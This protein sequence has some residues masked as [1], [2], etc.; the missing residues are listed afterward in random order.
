MKKVN[1][2]LQ[3]L[4]ALRAQRLA[5]P[6][7]LADGV[8][9]GGKAMKKT[10]KDS[11]PRVS[12]R[13]ISNDFWEVRFRDLDR[14]FKVRARAASVVLPVSDGSATG[15][16]MLTIESPPGRPRRRRYFS[17]RENIEI[18]RSEFRK[19]WER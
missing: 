19:R 5:L 12:T 4:R 14:V 16:E 13:W 18:S 15:F 1:E 2:A 11:R 10:A 9:A 6:E 17:S 7:A 3:R 8:G